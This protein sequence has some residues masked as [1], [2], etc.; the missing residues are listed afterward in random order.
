MDGYRL[1]DSVDYHQFASLAGVDEL[2]SQALFAYYAANAG[3]H[4]DAAEDLEG[5]TAP[6][7][8][9]FSFLRD[10]AESGDIPLDAE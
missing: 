3:E 4:R 10:K 2:T 9:L 7:I 8:D 6:I 1:G 5:Y